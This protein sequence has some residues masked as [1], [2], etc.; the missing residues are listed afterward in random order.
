MEM[1]SEIEAFNMLLWRTKDC[2]KNSK[3][4]F[5]QEFVSHKELQNLT[6]EESIKLC[7]N[8]T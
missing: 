1:P 4:T 5:A 7:K 3:N 6:A 8:K 2:Q